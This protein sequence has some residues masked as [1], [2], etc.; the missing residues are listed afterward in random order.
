M[1][2]HL[3][4]P[5]SATHPAKFSPHQQAPR[6]HH[7][8]KHTLRMSPPSCMPLRC[9]RRT[10][11]SHCLDLPVFLSRGCE[12]RETNPSGFSPIS[13]R[14]ST[15]KSVVNDHRFPNAIT[16][17]SHGLV[18]LHPVLFKPSLVRSLTFPKKNQGS[19][20]QELKAKLSATMNSMMS[21]CHLP[22]QP[23]T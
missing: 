21:C 14:F 3:G 4:F 2:I 1:L 23:T 10:L 12:T 13:G 16:R 20:N 17:Y 9:H 18:S 8:F 6:R 11:P 5:K 22:K 7:R 19:I 15:G